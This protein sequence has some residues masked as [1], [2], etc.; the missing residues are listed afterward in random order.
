M[1]ILLLGVAVYALLV[2]MFRYGR[3]GMSW[4]HSFLV[5]LVAAPV[6]LLWGWVRDH[7]NDRARE[8]G[9]RWRRRRQN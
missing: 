2:L 5:A 9:T 1:K 4:D 7:W 8:A 6:A 3:G